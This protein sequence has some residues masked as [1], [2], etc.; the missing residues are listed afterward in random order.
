MDSIASWTLR[1]DWIL[2]VWLFVLGGVV[3]SFLNVVV[4][5]VP[6]GKSIAH[7]GSQ[8]PACGCPIRWYHNLPIVSWLMLRGRCHDCGG[9]SPPGCSLV[10]SAPAPALARRCS[11]YSRAPIQ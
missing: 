1:L 10:G 8:C 5:R 11:L 3:G 9:G 2:D 4:Y 7:P 6:A